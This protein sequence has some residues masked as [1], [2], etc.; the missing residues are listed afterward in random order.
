[1][2][3]V[4]NP[5]A[6]LVAALALLANPL[7][8]AAAAQSVA[9]LEERQSEL[10]ALLADLANPGLRS[11]EATERK[12]ISHWSRSGSAAADLL[13]ERGKSAIEDEDYLT[14]VEHL[15]A[16]T[17]HAPDFA[18]GW[19]MRATAFFELEEFGLALA[20]LQRALMLNPRHFAALTGLGVIL[21]EL[22]S[23]ELALDAMRHAHALNPHR[24]NI[25]DAI[26]RLEYRLGET[27][28]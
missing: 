27:T 9:A 12:I 16:L 19:H 14:A 13:L 1:M 17:D 7:A 25:N 24:D 5:V 22:G 2:R 4:K 11:W 20:D 26:R 8:S 18:E 15:T 6:R 23:D 3:P 10:G 21:E 28:L